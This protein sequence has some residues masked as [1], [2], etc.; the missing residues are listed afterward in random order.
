MDLTKGQ[1]VYVKGY[2]GTRFMVK[3][4]DPKRSEPFHLVYPAINGDK[5]S[6]FGWCK[7]EEI[8]TE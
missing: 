7:A 4:I 8:I 3:E 2:A 6:E 5:E 1:I